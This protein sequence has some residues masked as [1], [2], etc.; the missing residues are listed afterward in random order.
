MKTPTPLTEPASFFRHV[1]RR[2]RL[3]II[4]ARHHL[5]A[6]AQ[7]SAALRHTRDHQTVAYLTVMARLHSESAQLAL[8]FLGGLA[9]ADTDVH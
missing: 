5:T 3:A 4:V 6:S 9:S 1:R 8:D 7:L 2:P